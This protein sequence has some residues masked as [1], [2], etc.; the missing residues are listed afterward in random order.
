MEH[1]HVVAAEPERRHRLEHRL[2]LLV[3]IGDQDEQAAAREVLGQLVH[4]RRQ[5]PGL[6]RLQPIED[7]QRRLHVLGRRR[8]VFDDVVV[9]RGEADAVALAVDQV[10]QA[11]GED[12]PVFELG[13]AAA[14]EAHRLRDV[15]QQA[16]LALVSASYSLM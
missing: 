9:E 7:V 3:E 4:R 2:R 8:H 6:R 10:G 12:A 15:E 1:D 11:A 16:K 14:A 5:L 13:D